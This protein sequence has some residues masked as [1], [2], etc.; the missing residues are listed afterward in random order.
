MAQGETPKSSLTTKQAT[1]MPNK[2]SH[3]HGEAR[4]W[5]NSLAGT[6]DT[7]SMGK[8]QVKTAR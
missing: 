6:L 1:A 3:S 5:A 2:A 8:T 7:N 4:R